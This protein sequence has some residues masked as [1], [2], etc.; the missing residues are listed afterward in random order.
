MTLKCLLPFADQDL[1]GEGVGVGPRSSASLDI[2]N[3]CLQKYQQKS[4]HQEEA[5]MFLVGISGLDWQGECKGGYL[6]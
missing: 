5:E 2:S 1:A 4:V 6:P 3:T